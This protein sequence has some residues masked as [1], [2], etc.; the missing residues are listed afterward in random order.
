M[1]ALKERTHLSKWGNSQATRIPKSLIE[2]LN[3][4]DNQEFNVSVKDGSLVLQPVK[5]EP[6]SIHELFANWKDDGIRD[7]ELDWG[8]PQGE[9]LQW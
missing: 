4:K 1:P 9:E 2:Q 7:H 8:E 6:S 3:L 5:D